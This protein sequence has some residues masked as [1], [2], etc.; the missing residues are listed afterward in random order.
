R[1][2]HALYRELIEQA[3][4]LPR[5]G[6]ENPDSPDFFAKRF[7]EI[8]ADALCERPYEG[9]DVLVV[10]EAQ[11]LLTPE[12]LDV[13]DLLLRGGLRR[14]RWHLFFDPQQNIYGADVQA[15]VEGR[16]SEAAPAFDDLFE[17]CRNTPQ[18]AVQT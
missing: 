17:N 10:D 3:G 18:V 4:L 13:F 1:H 9:W 7:P 8:A 6:A 12:H 5:L 11:D 2:V 16:L 15:Q 14:G